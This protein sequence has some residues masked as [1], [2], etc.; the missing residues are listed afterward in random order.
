MVVKSITKYLTLLLFVVITA[1]GYA[2][3]RDSAA[4]VA[5]L[6]AKA[7]TELSTAHIDYTAHNSDI[8]LSRQVSSPST[9][10][11]HSATK[12]TNNAHKNNFEFTKAGKFLNAC[13]GGFIHQHDLTLHA[14]FTKSNHRL[15]RLG[16]LII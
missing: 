4:V 10:Q 11:L 2:H 15:I 8:T 14:S 3:D 12:R 16:K 5:T 9:I 13:I 1:I 6:P 7:S